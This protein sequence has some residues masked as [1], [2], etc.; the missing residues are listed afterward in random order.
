MSNKYCGC[1]NKDYYD[2]DKEYY[3]WKE[4]KEYMDKYDKHDRYDKHE[5]YDYYYEN[6]DCVDCRK[7]GH[8]LPKPLLME[9]G[10]GNGYTFADNGE[11]ISLT[12]PC[13]A[14]RPKTLANVTIDTTCLCKPKTKI[15]FASNVHFVPFRRDG[16]GDLKFEFELVRKCDDGTETSLNTWLFEITD[17]RDNFAQTFSFMYCDCN[18]C[19]GCCEY[20]VRGI[21]LELDECSFCVTNCHIAALAQGDVAKSKY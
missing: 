17:E 20:Y 8:P 3:E 16:N 11:S 21:P 12:S 15:E 10:Q 7:P 6:K 13:T 5:K 2:Y 14:C 9:C 4:K 1:N 18:S 19:P